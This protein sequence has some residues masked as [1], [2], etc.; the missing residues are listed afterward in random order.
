[1]WM[2]P[3]HVLYVFLLT[4]RQ[5]EK[6]IYGCVA[7]I[8]VHHGKFWLSIS[9]FA[10]KKEPVV[11]IDLFHNQVSNFDHSGYGSKELFLANAEK[12][13]GLGEDDIH[14]VTADSSALFASNFSALGLHDFR[15]FS[16]DGGH[17]LENTLRDLTLASCLLVDGGILV[18]DDFINLDWLG[19]PTA[20]FNW[21]PEQIRVAPFL[22]A[23]NKLYFTTI[24]HHSAY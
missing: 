15:F 22:W 17:S 19:V 14:I 24:S 3:E 21:I 11:A 23:Y 4:S 5:H 9:G 12:A 6:G 16:V 8:G 7:E 20:V 10:D 2:M 1:G 13:L 18:V